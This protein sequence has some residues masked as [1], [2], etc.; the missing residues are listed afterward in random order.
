MK[1]SYN[2]LKDYLNFDHGPEEIS[3]RLTACGLEVEG[4]ERI[5]P[6]PGGF[7]GVVIGKVLHCEPHPNADRLTLTRVDVGEGEPLP[8]VCGAPNVADGQKVVVAKV[9]SLVRLGDDELKL[10]KTKIRGEVSEG[11]ICAEDE[12]GLGTSHDGILVLPDEAETGTPAREYFGVTTDWVFEI[13]LT[14]NR[15][16]AMSHLGVARDLAA[17]LKN[18]AYVEGTQSPE[19]RFPD[20]DAIDEIDDQGT[21]EVKVE[22]TGACPRYTSITMNGLNVGES[23]RWLQDRLKAIGLRPIN[24]LV[25]ISNYVLMETG[26]PLHF[27]DLDKVKGG[28]VVVKKLPPDTPFTTLDEVERKLS[29]EDLMIC[30]A[31]EGMCIAGV[32]GGN[33]SGVTEKTKSI[34]IESATFESVGIRKTSRRHDLKTDASFRFERGTDPDMTVFALKRAVR[35]IKEIAGGKVSSP[36]NDIYP[37]PVKA[38]RLDLRFSTV[39]TLIGKKID[40]DQI[41]LILRSLDFKIHEKKE[42]GFEIEV[43]P[44]RVEVTREADVIEEILRIYGYNNVE[45]PERLVSSLSYMDH[46]DRDKLR[47]QVSDMLVGQGWSEAMCNSLSNSE[48][49]NWQQEWKP[50]HCVRILNPVSQDLDVMRQTLVFGGLETVRYNRNRKQADLRIFEFGNRYRTDG[51]KP[52]SDNTLGPYKEDSAILLMLSGRARPEAWNTRDG[53]ADF[54]EL[55]AGLEALLAKL[56]IAEYSYGNS[57]QK[58][59]SQGLELKIDGKAAGWLGQIP[60]SLLGRFDIEAP[61]YAAEISWDILVRAAGKVKMKFHPVSRFPEVRRDLALVIDKGVTFHELKE[62]SF[63]AERKLLRSVNLFDVY[64]GK[65]IEEGKKSYALSFILQDEDKT[66]TDKLID[67][68]MKRIQTALEKAFDAKLR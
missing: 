58:T 19:L 29:A 6:V 46:P 33:K 13:G 7:E 49:Y 18:E 40:R 65:G 51:S 8:I 66:L 5:E 14:P 42:S 31:E 35:L 60:K 10:K 1:I 25:D 23:P 20:I 64:E 50:E 17:V 38:V 22:D 57:G 16:D 12:L 26:Q 55:K 21:I 54:F 63:R 39:D 48:Y 32:F 41:E 36:M 27:F 24:N 9:G 43:P 59:L 2:W 62:E 53:D 52:S 28:R 47:N 37:E 56:G 34:F 15:A 3:R 4:L 44:Y 68:A 61:V 45:F 67:K 30:N 11:M